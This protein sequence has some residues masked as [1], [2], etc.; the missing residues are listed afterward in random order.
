MSQKV[1]HPL[2]L[3]LHRLA[4]GM[5][6]LTTWSVAIFF[7]IDFWPVIRQINPTHALLI[8]LIVIMIAV[9]TLLMWV[10]E[11]ATGTKILQFYTVMGFFLSLAILYSYVGMRLGLEIRDWIGSKEI[12]QLP[13]TQ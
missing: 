1:F 6:V 9:I 13:V 10:G 11:I 8:L 3:F 5:F 7:V 4:L 2:V 12:N